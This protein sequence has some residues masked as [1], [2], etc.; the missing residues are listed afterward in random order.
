MAHPNGG[1][2]PLAE[3]STAELIHRA[4]EQLSQLVQDELRL[5]RVELTRKGRSAGIGAGLFGGAGVLI[6]YGTAALVATAVL[7]LAEVL[8]GWLAA[9][10]VGVAL[11]AVAGLMA[12]I[13]RGQ[14]R[15]AAPP[16]P[17][18]AV[19]SVRADIDAVTAAVRDSRGKREVP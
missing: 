19:R 11:F 7:G 2:R 17:E 15:R 14:V 4:T 9:L 12:L 3:Q 5:A 18:G 1:P 16:V 8:P 10:I 6:V 13:G